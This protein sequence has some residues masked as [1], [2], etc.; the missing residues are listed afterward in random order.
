MDLQGKFSSIQT[1]FPEPD[2]SATKAR[3]DLNALRDKL[4]AFQDAMSALKEFSE[5]ISRSAGSEID[6]W[7][8]LH[9][10]LAAKLLNMTSD[11]VGPKLDDLQAE[12]RAKQ[13][14][15]QSSSDS[16]TGIVPGNEKNVQFRSEAS[17][18]RH[19]SY[20]G[21]SFL[22]KAFHW[23]PRGLSLSRFRLK[24]Y[25]ILGYVCPAIVFIYAGITQYYWSNP[26]FGSVSEYVSLFLWGFAADASSNQ[27]K[28]L[29]QRASL[30]SEVVA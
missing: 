21:A 15:L 10:Q 9:M 19:L 17:Q 27:V 14:E 26:V 18:V 11:D 16:R 24:G 5:Q 29:I 20:N 3:Q 7:R 23:S 13:A 30:N 8:K 4:V 22:A 28:D 6:Q 25:K 2:Y 12:I 1:R